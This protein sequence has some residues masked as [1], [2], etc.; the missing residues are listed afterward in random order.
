MPDETSP[1]AVIEAVMR[2]N[3]VEVFAT[4]D[5]ATRRGLVDELYHPDAEFHDEDGTVTG[6]SDRR[7]LHVPRPAVG[8]GDDDAPARRARA[9]AIG[10]NGVS[11]PSRP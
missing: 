2:R 6:R 8:P 5:D 10:Q 3:V 11:S 4:T 9:G 7:A 1:A